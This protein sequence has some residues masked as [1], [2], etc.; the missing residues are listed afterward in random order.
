MEPAQLIRAATILARNP[1]CGDAEVAQ[2]LVKD[3]FAVAVALLLV[4]FLPS[5]FARPVLERLGVSEFVDTASVLMANGRLL[6]VRLFDQPEYV[7]ALALAREHWV[8][9]IIPRAVYET[10]VNRTSEIDAVSKALNEGADVDG[11]TIAIALSDVHAEHIVRP[12]LRF[13]KR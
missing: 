6:N 9:G 8:S 1:S 3:G 11:A 5:A 13:W 2:L 4:A 12:R 7:A 10:I